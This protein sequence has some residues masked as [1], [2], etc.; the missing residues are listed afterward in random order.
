MILPSGTQALNLLGTYLPSSLLVGGGVAGVQHLLAMKREQDKADE[1]S[2]NRKDV[3][4]VPVSAPKTAAGGAAGSIVDDLFRAAE[5]AH[6]PI[7]TTL[8]RQMPE[9]ALPAFPPARTPGPVPPVAPAAPPADLGDLFHSAESAHP[10]EAIPAGAGGSAGG[11]GA[12]AEA[13]GAGAG[14]GA[15]GADIGL[16]IPSHQPG[17]FG[18]NWKWMTGVG[19]A[20]AAGLGLKN[21]NEGSGTPSLMD[22]AAITGI[23]G[24]GLMGGYSLVNHL[25]RERKKKALTEQ[26]AQAKN[27]Y[28]TMLGQTLS[29]TASTDGLT[30]F[31]LIHG[32]LQDFALSRADDSQKNASTSSGMLLLGIPG[33]LGVLSAIAA[34]KWVYNRQKELEAMHTASKPSPPRQIRLQAVP[35]PGA[36]QDDD[37]P[38][39]VNGA[40]EKYAGL[41]EIMDFMNKAETPA[42]SEQQAE[43]IAEPVKTQVVK[44][45]PG[46]IQITGKGHPPTE[47]EADSPESAEILRRSA[48]RLAKLLAAY[49]STPASA[50]AA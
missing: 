13:G 27:E 45:A 35:P 33:G 29:K 18:K 39:S 25:M 3:L 46:V 34:H 14:A 36:E 9:A 37:Q 49:Q 30:E 23:V 19:G 28:A 24:G 21:Y 16:N 44:V 12:G 31:P 22:A 4:V 8:S 11:G 17:W 48:P 7:S 40:D 26:L 50:M 10:T 5:A 2:R 32:I 43:A 38:L 20:G 15:G 1:E 42:I 6:P 41:N 47:V